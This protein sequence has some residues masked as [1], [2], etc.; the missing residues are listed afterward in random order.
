MGSCH[1]N[2]GKG[3]VNSY[4]HELKFVLL[5]K[6]SSWS[7]MWQSEIYHEICEPL[8]IQVFGLLKNTIESDKGFFKFWHLPKTINIIMGKTWLK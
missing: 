1:T 8:S 5:K 6:L 4:C 2:T 3:S 7:R